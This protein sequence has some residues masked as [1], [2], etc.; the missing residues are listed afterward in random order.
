MI[1]SDGELGS[2]ESEL[3]EIGELVGTRGKGW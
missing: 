2:E 3:L 1:E